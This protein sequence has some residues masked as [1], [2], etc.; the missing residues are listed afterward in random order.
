MPAKMDDIV[1]KL[2]AEI[3]ELLAFVKQEFIKIIREMG[4][5]EIIIPESDVKIVFFL[6]SKAFE[7][8]L[9]KAERKGG[10]IRPGSPIERTPQTSFSETDATTL[11]LQSKKR[12]FHIL[13]NCVHI[14]NCAFRLQME[15]K[16]YM[17]MTL[18]HEMIHTLESVTG[19]SILRSSILKDDGFTVSIYEDWKM[20]R[21]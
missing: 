14:R 16:G 15:L 2:T 7:K 21:S 10:K 1:N 8:T 4:K 9:M 20:R 13:L 5:P 19:I 11:K 3:E 18:I 12:A 17:T 6:K